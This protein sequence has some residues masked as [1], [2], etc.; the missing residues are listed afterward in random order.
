MS[1]A[2]QCRPQSVVEDT[3]L[4]GSETMTAM[5]DAIFK[6]SVVVTLPGEIVDSDA[7]SV[8]GDTAT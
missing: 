4:L 8:D 2:P 3:E 7:D 5:A 6:I 1:S